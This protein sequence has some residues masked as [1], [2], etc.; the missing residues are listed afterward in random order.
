LVDPLHI[1]DSVEI[2]PEQEGAVV[3]FVPQSLL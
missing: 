2:F 3:E 1:E